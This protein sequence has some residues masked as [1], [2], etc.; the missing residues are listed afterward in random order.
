M[1]KT[2]ILSFFMP[3]LSSTESQGTNKHSI[4]FRGQQVKNNN[5]VNIQF[6][7]ETAHFRG[8]P[9]WWFECFILSPCCISH[10]LVNQGSSVLHVRLP[11]S[12][13]PHY[14]RTERVSHMGSMCRFFYLP[15]ALLHLSFPCRCCHQLWF[16]VVGSH[17]AFFS[18]LLTGSNLQ[19][20]SLLPFSLLLCRLAP[21][22]DL[23]SV[24]SLPHERSHYRPRLAVFY[25][26]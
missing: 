15:A 3:F 4:S 8:C 23:T 20:L 14:G 11:L 10:Y 21:T 25:T 12:N 2:K 13:E 16:N 9:P 17:L 7:A 1:T 19:Q 5:S 18:L 6:A 22:E 26:V 24:G